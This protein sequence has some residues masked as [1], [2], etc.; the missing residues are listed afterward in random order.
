MATYVLGDVHG[1]FDTLTLILDEIG[2][3][4]GRDQLWTVGDLVNRG[5]SSLATLRW[6]RR[7]AAGMGAR[8]HSV[9]GNQDLHPLAC[10]G[11]LDA[12][13]P[14]DTFHDV[15]AAPDRD[16][17]LAW[18]AALPFAVRRGG[19]L[20]VHAGLHP[21]WGADQALALS[22]RLQRAM[23]SPRRREILTRLDD[24][25]RGTPLQRRVA[26]FTRIRTCTPCGELHPYNGPPAGA[27]T[28]FF[29]WFEIAGRRSLDH[30]VIFGHWAALGLHLD[31]RVIGLDS[32]CVWGGELTA[33]RLEDRALF[34]HRVLPHERIDG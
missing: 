14:R 17:L 31:E 34:Q 16:E 26:A 11:G 28:G 4:P 32:G 6:A 10:A 27:P 21:A 25:H 33:I 30:T 7:Q 3:D 1:C 18:L 13:R 8:F 24:P 9:L 15:L 19:H 12:P 5:P 23:A 29:P 22:G 2:L 20:L